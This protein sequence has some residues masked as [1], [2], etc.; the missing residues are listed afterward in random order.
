ME[1][2]YTFTGNYS[3]MTGLKSANQ[4]RLRGTT[5]SIPEDDDEVLPPYR[6]YMTIDILGNQP[7]QSA[8]RVSLRIYDGDGTTLIESIDAQDEE[9]TDA[10]DLQGRKVPKAQ[11]KKGIYIINHKKRIIE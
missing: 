9:T 2:R 7:Q 1:A 10:Y 6:W 5:L 3:N 4:Y 11:M 8:R